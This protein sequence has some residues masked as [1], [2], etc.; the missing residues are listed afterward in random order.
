MRALAIIGPTAS[1]KTSLS[2]A[3]AKKLGGEIICCDSMQLYRGLSIGTAKP[4]EEEM[5]ECPHHLFDLADPATPMNAADYADAALKAVEDIHSRGALPIFCGGT[6]LYLEA[7]RTLRHTGDTPASDPDLRDALLNK[8]ATPEGK[9]SLY[10]FLEQIDPA[11]AH[12]THPNNLPRVVR[13]LEIYYLTGR[14]KTELDAC[15]STQNTSLDLTVLCLYYQDRALL[16]ERIS[17]RVS[18]MLEAGLP[19]EAR[20]A[21]EAG[22]LSPDSGIS[23]AIGYKELLPYLKGEEPLEAAVER[24]TVATCRYAKRQMTFFRHMENVLF[25]PCDREGQPLTQ[26]QLLEEALALL[27]HA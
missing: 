16:R 4:T 2:I 24:L 12:A 26:S 19:E 27:G 3:L 9:A 25:L 18:L 14:T 13:A 22:L 5:A 17:R 6:G 23:R 7:V 10:R 1:G 8:G 11:A 21:Y 15:A 20:D